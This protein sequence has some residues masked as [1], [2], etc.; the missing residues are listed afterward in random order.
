MDDRMDEH[1][2]RVE[3]FERRQHPQVDD[4]Q[5]FIKFL[6]ST[7]P[8]VCFDVLSLKDTQQMKTSSACSNTDLSSPESNHD[9]SLESIMD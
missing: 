3:D 1:L 7:I 5:L 6:F 8:A 9:D 4:N 2:R